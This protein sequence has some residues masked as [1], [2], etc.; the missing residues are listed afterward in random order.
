MIALG[1]TAVFA[2]MILG[3]LSFWVLLLVQFSALPCW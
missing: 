3:L 1:T 2:S